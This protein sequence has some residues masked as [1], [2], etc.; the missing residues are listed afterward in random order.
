[1]Y[2]DPK[3]FSRTPAQRADQ[4]LAWERDDRYFFASGAC[5]ILAFTF[6]N[7]HPDRSLELVFIRP[8]EKFVLAGCHMFVRDGEWAFDHAGWTK[9]SELLGVYAEGFREAF[10]GWGYSLEVITDNLEEFCRKNDHRGP[11]YFYNLPWERT[12]RYIKQFD[13]KPPA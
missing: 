12:Y 2:L 13:E 7:L 4:S 11:A 9:E 3:K 6:K 5:H 8:L 10:P 1:M